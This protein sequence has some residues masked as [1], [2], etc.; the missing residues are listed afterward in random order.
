[1]TAARSICLKWAASPSRVNVIDGVRLRIEAV[2]AVG[3]PT[4]VFAYQ[5][6]PMRPATNESVAAFDHVCSPPDLADY[7][8]DAPLPGSRPDWLRTNFVDLLLRSNHEAQAVL[9]QVIADV[10]A[11]KFSLDAT[12]KLQPGGELWIGTPPGGVSSSIGGW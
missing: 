12:D 5:S 4:K 2:D 11:L 1:M 7:P 10:A 6:L 8:E 3:M 9:Q